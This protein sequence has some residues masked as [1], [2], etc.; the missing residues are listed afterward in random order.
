MENEEETM[1]VVKI[2]YEAFQLNG[3]HPQQAVSSMIYMISA[4]VQLQT[5]NPREILC[6]ISQDFLN[7]S[8]AVEKNAPEVKQD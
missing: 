8:Q 3:I 5:N 7:L 2:V 4:I 6:M 1:K